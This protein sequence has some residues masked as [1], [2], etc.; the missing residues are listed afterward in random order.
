MSGLTIAWSISFL[1]TICV[2][3]VG[4]VRLVAIGS[5]GFERSRTMKIAAGFAVTV[6]AF[7]LVT[8]VVL[9]VVMIAD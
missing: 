7:A 9:T 6:G 2:L 4:L 8:T 5:G 1:V 3:P